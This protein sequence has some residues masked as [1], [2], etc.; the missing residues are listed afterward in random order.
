MKRSTAM[1]RITFMI[2]GVEVVGDLHVPEDFDERKSYAA[3]VLTTPGSSVKEQVGG[4]YASRMAERG[5]VALT[6]DP[7]HQGESGGEPRGLED[8]A[9][10]VED[11]KCAVDWLLSQP[12]V[13]EARLGLL[14]LCAGGGYAIGAALSDHRFKA[15]GTVVANDIGAAFRSF[16]TQ[17]E[18]LAKIADVGRQRTAEARGAPLRYDPWIPD[19]LE[20]ARNQGITDRDTLEAVYFYRESQYRNARSDNRLLFTSFSQILSFEVMSLV[21]DL[22]IQPLSVIVGGRR[23]STPQYEAGERLF[24]LSP[25]KDKEFLAVEGAGHYEM[26]HKPEYVGPAVD[27]LTAFFKR[28]L[29]S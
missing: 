14:G 6:F 19:S 11:V 26:Y 20:D 24:A 5:F 27:R 7:A 17:E 10:R 15:I 8:P 21:P 25:S 23:G 22:L 28:H 13:D 9:V 16:H 18:L 12:F 4:I 29:G 2:R 3:L 1:K